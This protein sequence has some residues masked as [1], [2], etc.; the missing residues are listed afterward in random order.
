[1][2]Q[3]PGVALEGTTPKEGKKMISVKSEDDQN[4]SNHSSPENHHLVENKAEKKK[5]QQQQAASE[6][7]PAKPNALREG[8]ASAGRMKQNS[9]AVAVK[10]ETTKNTNNNQS[11]NKSAK[12]TSVYKGVAQHRVTRRWESHVWENKKQIYLGSFATELKAAQAYDKAAIFLL[13]DKSTLNFP[14]E[15][16]AEEADKISRMTKEQLLAHLRRGSNGFSR[17]RTKFRGVSYRSHTG[18]WEAR[19]SGVETNKYTYLGTFDTPQEAA[20][21]YDKAAIALKGKKAVTNFDMSNYESELGHLTKLTP[22]MLGKDSLT[23]QIAVRA[24]KEL[25]YKDI[26]AKGK[27]P[28]RVS[29][30]SNNQSSCTTTTTTAGVV[31]KNRNL[32]R[33]LNFCVRPQLQDNNV[34]NVGK[35]QQQSR[36]KQKPS[37]RD[38]SF[39]SDMKVQQAYAPIA[40]VV[41]GNVGRYGP[42]MMYSPAENLDWS[43]CEQ[44]PPPPPLTPLQFT[45]N[46][47][48]SSGAA[49]SDQTTAGLLGM[50]CYDENN[51]PHHHHHHQQQGNMNNRNS[52]NYFGQFNGNPYQHGNI[53]PGM[54]KTVPDMDIPITAYRSQGPPPPMQTNCLN[55]FLRQQAVPPTSYQNFADLVPGLEQPEGELQTQTQTKD[56]IFSGTGSRPLSQVNSTDE[57]QGASH[58]DSKSEFDL[59]VE[60][61]LDL[62]SSNDDDAIQQHTANR[63]SSN[64]AIEENLSAFLNNISLNDIP[65]LQEGDHE[66]LANDKA[67]LDFQPINFL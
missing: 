52:N 66:A 53:L 4:H 57:N 54:V 21:A 15:N 45:M 6:K 35:K 56:S 34:P 60:K 46:P 38:R 8:N 7:T 20:V 17:G 59:Y 31:N 26:V 32:T 55:D 58:F 62:D 36:R 41:G 22:D 27:K 24:N 10:P 28:G 29:N 47:S 12:G 40:K 48:Q 5:K 11:G 61:L 25:Y 1:V 37:K 3:E 18:R 9:K 23:T 16:Y 33:Q 39:N 44:Y 67:L 2:K 50:G 49:Y 65:E 64:A 42:A 30:N 13:K 63:N 14:I 19:I 51:A 43:L